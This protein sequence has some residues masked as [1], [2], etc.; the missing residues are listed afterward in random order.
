MRTMAQYL[1][2]GK[3]KRKQ[4]RHAWHPNHND[5][6]SLPY[7]C[8]L[9]GW[10]PALYFLFSKSTPHKKQTHFGL[11]ISLEA[12]EL[13]K[14]KRSALLPSLSA[15]AT[16]QT[17]K[18]A[19]SRLQAQKVHCRVQLLDAVLEWPQNLLAQSVSQLYRQMGTGP[20]QQPNM[21]EKCNRPQP[22][23]RHFGRM[24]STAE[25]LLTRRPPRHAELPI[26]VQVVVRFPDTSDS[27]AQTSCPSN[28]H[29][30]IVA[31]Q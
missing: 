26:F 28:F 6:D 21:P 13:A 31:C 24:R 23:R 18:P 7:G 30:G 2:H 1:I 11:A 9:Q 29:S 22:D 5:W 14:K 15:P 10:T 3:Q 19:A 25:Q 8:L 27:A 17:A 16:V 20:S 4:Q 12:V